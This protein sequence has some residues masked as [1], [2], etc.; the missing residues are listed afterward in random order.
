MEIRIVIDFLERLL[1]G[2]DGREN[3]RGVASIESAN[4]LLFKE[5]VVHQHLLFGKLA[6]VLTHFFKLVFSVFSLLNR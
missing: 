5:V 2:R 3:L 6:E 1:D 4:R